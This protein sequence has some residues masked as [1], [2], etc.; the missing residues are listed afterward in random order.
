MSKEIISN[1]ADFS[2]N[3]SRM[4]TL[5]NNPTYDLTRQGGNKIH[6]LLEKV[7]R[8]WVAFSLRVDA[9]GMEHLRGAVAYKKENAVE[10]LGDPCISDYYSMHVNGGI[11]RRF[12]IYK[13]DSF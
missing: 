10:V 1:Q 7:G 12:R 6:L 11:S 13:S 2:L 3:E 8:S 9:E 5:K 4:D